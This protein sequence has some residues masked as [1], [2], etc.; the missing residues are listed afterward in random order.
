M[1][2]VIF[3]LILIT[4][5]SFSY[6]IYDVHP[7]KWLSEISN[8]SPE[9]INKLKK[10]LK[11]DGVYWNAYP[12]ADQLIKL[13]QH[14]MLSIHNMEQLLYSDDHQQRQYAAWII[15]RAVPHYDS[16]ILYEIIVESLANDNI[17]WDWGKGG[18]VQ[19]PH[20]DSGDNFH[21]P[22]FY[23][24]TM[25]MQDLMQNYNW[26][27]T[28]PLINGLYSEDKQLSFFSA[29]ILAENQIIDA[30]ERTV[31]VLCDNLKDDKIPHNGCMAFSA[32]YNLGEASCQ[33]MYKHYQ[34]SKDEQEKESILLLWKYLEFVP[35]EWDQINFESFNKLNPK[36]T[37]SDYFLNYNRKIF[38]LG[39]K[40]IMEA[41]FDFPEK[42]S[43]KI[44]RK[45]PNPLIASSWE[46]EETEIP[47]FDSPGSNYFRV[48]ILPGE[49][50]N[51]IAREYKVSVESIKRVNQKLELI[52]DDNLDGFVG[53]TLWIPE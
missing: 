5:L 19:F 10:D 37:N 35:D 49:T 15:K 3:F 43:D 32:L 1:M 44:D 38:I 36:F 45:A 34:I 53:T 25:A 51:D 14:N 21:D 11:D 50:L 20:K 6:Q 12:A 26:Y 46:Y 48:L 52:P 4:K 27:A 39:Q 9:K 28:E 24:A 22:Y 33:H 30:V 42:G 31:E 29:V 2:R 13:I 47:V 18:V 17:P 41:R 16:P 40:K 7:D 8:Y 23:N